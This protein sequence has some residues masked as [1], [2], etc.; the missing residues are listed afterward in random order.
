[1]A[2]NAEQNRQLG[3]A[4]KTVAIILIAVFAIKVTTT[5]SVKLLSLPQRQKKFQLRHPQLDRSR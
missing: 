4:E 1:M 5:A 3:K 2:G